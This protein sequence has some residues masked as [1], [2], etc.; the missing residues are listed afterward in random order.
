MKIAI[1]GTRHLG[2]VTAACIA[3]KGVDVIAYDPNS[4]MIQSLQ[5]GLVPFLEPELPELLASSGKH[6]FFT[7]NIE[8]LSEAEIVWVTFDTPMV[9]PSE[10]D[11][12]FITSEII[13][14]FPFL[15][16]HAVLLISSQIPVGT[17]RT[18]QIHCQNHFP[19]KKIT[20]AYSPE[21]LKLGQAIQ[22]F[23]NPAR[24]IVGSESDATKKIIQNLLQLFTTQIIWMSLESAEMT[25]HAL[26][27]FLATSVI[28]INEL[29]TLC[30]QVGAD[31]YEVE[32]GLKSEPR[33][34]SHAYLKPGN[35]IGGGT[36]MRD[37]RY[38]IKIA[39]RHHIQ[40]PLFSSLPLSNQTHK[41]W[42]CHKLTQIFY[43]LKDKVITTLGLTYKPGT[44]SI[45]QSSAIETCEWLL[46]QGAK[47]KAY[48]PALQKL[49]KTVQAPIQLTPT[50]NEALH[51]ADAVVIATGWPEFSSI[52]PEL[53]LTTT[54]QPHV[55]DVSGL[56]AKNLSTDARIHYY[57]VGRSS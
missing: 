15:K 41:Y 13:K 29:A 36:L 57:T 7:D 16:D 56:L 19:N 25:K 49:P 17:T 10:P 18:L 11:I 26:N 55:L 34:G 53:I 35:A 21:N 12:D 38:L 40:T 39:D 28:F 42:A 44:D 24:I 2:I 54:Q 8:T 6:L 22:A 51:Q 20:F 43:S 47:V 37:V 45:E 33:I 48:D 5:Q 52:L 31:A 46:K 1:V 50:L 32:T 9:N 3:S 23:M 30:E 4:A 27:A 14:T